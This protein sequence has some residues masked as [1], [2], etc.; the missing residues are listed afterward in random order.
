MN[1]GDVED[2]CHDFRKSMSLGN[3]RAADYIS[4]NC[5]K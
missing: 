2:A 4:S 1:S 5:I 3:K